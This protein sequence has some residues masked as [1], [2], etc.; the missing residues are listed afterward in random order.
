MGHGGL[1][2]T[3]WVGAGWRQGSTGQTRETSC[4][5][6]YFLL[7]LWEALPTSGSVPGSLPRSAAA[8]D[9]RLLKSASDPSTGCRSG[10]RHF[11]ENLG[12]F[13]WQLAAPP[14]N[15][16][17]QFVPKPQTLNPTF[18]QRRATPTATQEKHRHLPTGREL[19]LKILQAA[20]VVKN[21]KSN[22]GP[23]GVVDASL[24]PQGLFDGRSCSAA[25]GFF[26]RP[27]CFA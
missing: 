21:P 26:R 7:L 9:I 17:Q 3:P 15:E 18:W 2:C 27:G 12:C 14:K 23:G 6:P 8:S 22:D 4:P 5:R 16:H 10:P 25:V 1:V 13:F 24:L 20:S 19:A 11:G